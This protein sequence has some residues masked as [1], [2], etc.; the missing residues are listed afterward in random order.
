MDEQGKQSE[1]LILTNVTDRIATLTFNQP[2][3]LNALSP[4]LEFESIQ[5]LKQWSI[6]PNIG[7]IV[8]TGAGRAFCVGGDVSKMDDGKGELLAGDTFE[9]H[10]DGLRR[11]H[12]LA[13][14]LYHMPK[15][16]IAAVN[17]HAMGAGLAICLACDLQIAS[18]KAKFGA[19]YARVGLGGD[20]GISWLLT[21]YVGAAKAK[22]LLFLCDII[23]AT[24]ASRIGLVNR[25]VPQEEFS[26][27]VKDIASRI[28]NGTGISYRYMKA[29]INFAATAD[30]RTLLDREAETH[31]LCGKTEDFKEGVL[32]FM[33]KR[34]PR[35]KGR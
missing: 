10:V 26:T 28:A 33:E 29:N 11:E 27:S 34:Q 31:L 2:Q 1:A 4:E 5:I 7:A 18:D 17:G 30:F 35:F 32:A 12:E 15:V 22:E 13:W 6:D 16:T 21:H 14:L 20:F 25:V 23:D 19:A 24:E 3:K 9:Q 8:L